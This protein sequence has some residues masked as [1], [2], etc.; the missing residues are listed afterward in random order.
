M[1][2]E[3]A[4]AN[5]WGSI[6]GIA[7]AAARDITSGNDPHLPLIALDSLAPCAQCEPMTY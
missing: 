2:L 5:Y 3:T 1:A 6:R 7:I 4:F